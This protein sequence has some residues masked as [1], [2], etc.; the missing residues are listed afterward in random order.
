MPLDDIMALPLDQ[1]TAGVSEVAVA[2]PSPMPESDDD[3]NHEPEPM[4]GYAMLKFG[5]AKYF[6]QT[7]SIIVG[8]DMRAYREIQLQHER[9]MT[10]L[11]PFQSVLNAVD[12]LGEQPIELSTE[13]L[14]PV[15]DAKPDSNQPTETNNATNVTDEERQTKLEEDETEEQA[16]LATANEVIDD[17]HY[18]IQTDDLV[19]KSWEEYGT[20]DC[21]FLAIHQPKIHQLPFLS[22]S[23]IS[24]KHAK[25]EYN[26]DTEHFE[27][28]VFGKNGA[29]V[30]RKYVPPG[31]CYALRDGVH[32][33]LASV[34]FEFILP[35]GEEEE[36]DPDS[37]SGRMS[38]AF[39]GV[40]LSEV[41]EDSGDM[42][43]HAYD[44][45]HYNV[46]ST[47]TESGSDDSSGQSD[48][49]ESDED[50]EDDDGQEEESEVDQDSE[51]MAVDSTRLKIQLKANSKKRKDLKKSMKSH[52]R[53]KHH[54]KPD[55][56]HKHGTASKKPMKSTEKEEK[57]SS[58]AAIT[59]L[60]TKVDPTEEKDDQ[61]AKG[62]K[63]EPV[64]RIARDEPLQ[65]G[66]GV[67]IAG[68]PLGMVIPARRK[69]PG[70]P[71]KDG[72][73]SKRERSQLLRAWKEQEKAKKLGLDP[74]KIV[75]PEPKKPT[76]PRKNSKG[77][78][79]TE[80][81]E[82]GIK[83][84]DDQDR[85]KPAR[86][87]RS[88]SPQMREED[89]TEEQLG[90]PAGNYVMFIYDAV[91]ASAEKKLNLQ[92][93][94]SAIERKYPYF[95]F[96][97]NTPGWQSSVRHNLGQHPAFEKVE[98]DGK[99]YLWGI[100]EGVPIDRERKK[101]SPPPP[102]YPPPGQSYAPNTY[103]HQHPQHVMPGQMPP[104]G[105]SNQSAG[106]GVNHGVGRPI[107]TP[108][109]TSSGLVPS[110][111]AQSS[112][113]TRPQS[114][115]SP[116]STPGSRPSS[117]SA[118]THYQSTTAMPRNQ[119]LNQQHNSTITR[120]TTQSSGP[121]TYQRPSDDVIDVFKTVFKK[122]L[123][124]KGGPIDMDTAE[125]IVNNAVKRVLEP[126]TMRDVPMLDREQSVVDAF[127]SCLERSQ[128]PPR[129]VAAPTSF[130]TTPRP[131]VN[132]SSGLRVSTSLSNSSS[133]SPIPRPNGSTVDSVSNSNTHNS[134]ASIRPQSSKL[135]IPS[136]A[137]VTVKPAS[138]SA[139]AVTT[140]INGGAA[141]L[142]ASERVES[143]KPPA[144]EAI[145]PPDTSQKRGI[146]SVADAE[147]SAAK[148]VIL[149]DAVAS[150][151]GKK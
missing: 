65:N 93:I 67:E 36:R 123:P 40:N 102:V 107:A 70:R 84:G 41:S 126:E 95:K 72:V 112:T 25:I 42:H 39:E 131:G 7:T 88:P 97:V 109:R 11:N 44:S 94:Y 128:A 144:V 17:S 122:S 120:P 71:P 63:E 90:R 62:D 46:Y 28:W 132:G 143:P 149:K 58:K 101:R 57:V 9:E 118:Q 20:P 150:L 74:S 125:K 85:K 69:G 22:G 8:R 2:S 45:F 81:G 43:P 119:S 127:R 52:S 5:D 49:D 96:R 147:E 38:F 59:K 124:S 116:Y 117:S 54:G 108:Q 130:S 99:G 78:D 3:E 68:L 115:S 64:Q 140:A 148:K 133:S 98:K 142:N 92:Q 24:R 75:I 104:P 15:G 138:G 26:P 121:I 56:K 106:Y 34:E 12:N 111:I 50:E 30:N 105:N 135:A 29:F 139:V 61:K 14:P 79:V 76:R 136:G 113:G 87:P 86:P 51:E 73:M 10:L 31:E 60:K 18:L 16:L 89:Y 6:M 33:Q 32:I 129:S 1:L 66:E 4:K 13:P 21:P 37:V 80:D 53:H 23:N 151:L 82:A 100:K 103:Q 19:I 55:L 134:A 83:D 77:E 91:T 47:H 146:D 48:D 114:Y 35:D 145:T 141:L 27:L 137:T 110:T